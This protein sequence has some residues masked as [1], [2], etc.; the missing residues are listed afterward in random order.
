MGCKDSGPECTCSPLVLSEA[1]TEGQ[2][3]SG[4]QVQGY[5]DGSYILGHPPQDLGDA[6]S[7]SYVCCPHPGSRSS[8]RS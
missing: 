4:H 1:G 2:C 5:V 6:S 7:L 3:P 8:G